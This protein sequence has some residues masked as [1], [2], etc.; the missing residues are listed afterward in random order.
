MTNQHKSLDDV[1]RRT[2]NGHYVKQSNPG[3]RPVRDQAVSHAIS[4]MKKSD[5]TAGNR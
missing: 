1:A 2:A 4:Q 3:V 5:S